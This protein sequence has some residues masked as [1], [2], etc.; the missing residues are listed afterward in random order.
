MVKLMKFSGFFA[1]AVT[2]FAAFV[3]APFGIGQS[4]RPQQTVHVDSIGRDVTLIGRLG[5]PLGTKMTLQGKWGF[6]ETI[7]K[8]GSIRFTVHSV[9]RKPISPQVTFN[10][11][12]MRLLDSERR[13]ARPSE[14]TWTELNEDE[15]T[16]VAYETGCIRITPDEYRNAKRDF[17][18]IAMPYYTEPFTSELVAVRVQE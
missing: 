4:T 16:M 17:P 8:D 5:E 13:E 15:W 11:Y 6:P 2:S 9:N 18:Q 10:I 14:N 3:I 1:I 7:A 12:Q